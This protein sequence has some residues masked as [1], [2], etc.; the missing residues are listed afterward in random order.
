M[1]ATYFPENGA[2]P[3]SPCYATKYG[4]DLAISINES[5]KKKIQDSGRTTIAVLDKSQLAEWR[6]A[7]TPLYKKFEDEIGKDLIN[8]ALAANKSS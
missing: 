3:A 5:D 2:Y 7:M 1:P 8:A 4:N 6:K